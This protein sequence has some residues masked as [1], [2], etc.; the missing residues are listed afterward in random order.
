MNEIVIL[1][2]IVVDILTLPPPTILYERGSAENM[3]NVENDS[4]LTPV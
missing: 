1:V 4:T 3:C 2:K